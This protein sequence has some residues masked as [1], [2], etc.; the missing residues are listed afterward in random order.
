MRHFR[1]GL[2]GLQKKPCPDSEPAS[3]YV[4][5]NACNCP[6]KRMRLKHEAVTVFPNAPRGEINIVL[7]GLRITLTIDES[8]LLAAGLADSLE[9]LQGT[10]QREVAAAETWDVGRT[11][12]VER[13]LSSSSG[14]EAATDSVL[15]R[16]RALIQASMREKGLSLRE[17]Q[18]E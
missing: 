14:K 11:P 18:T 17:T 5:E 9:Q 7:A 10:D 13:E 8:L 15:M 3:N 2:T 1:G 6:R 4:G 12:P 16:T